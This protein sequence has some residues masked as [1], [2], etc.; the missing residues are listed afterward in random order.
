[1]VT[2]QCLRPISVLLASRDPRFLSATGFFLTRNGF[3]V[4]TTR[5]LT[6]LADFMRLKPANVVVL[7]A[8]DSPANAVRT[9]AAIERESPQTRVV[10]VAEEPGTRPPWGVELVPKWGPIEEVV[11]VVERVYLRAP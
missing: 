8:G 6:R 3:S 7:D 4:Q 5:T 9:A 10:L 1:V 11:S 2:V